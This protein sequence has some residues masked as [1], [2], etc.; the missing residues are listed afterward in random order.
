MAMTELLLERLQ[1]LGWSV[2]QQPV[3][4]LPAPILARYSTLPA[5]VVRFISSLV[6]CHN[7]NQ[8]AWFLTPEDYART[9][10]GERFAWNEFEHMA[11]ENVET[12]EERR[13]IEVF[14][15]AHFPLMLAVHSCYEY[16]AVRV[17]G[18]EIGSIVHGFAP[19][20][21]EP[22]PIAPDFS[23]FL[24]EF[25]GAAQE[26]EPPWPYKLFL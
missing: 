11:L 20:W 22:T 12:P 7:V 6:V 3:V 14:W 2:E 24:E 13:Y 16:L 26:A 15:D 4:E 17:S 18:E 9:P 1:S 23:T 5:K 25:A 21:E 10:G 8:A 19:Y